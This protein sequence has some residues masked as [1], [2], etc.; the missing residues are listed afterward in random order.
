MTSH[1]I[2]YGED[3][4]DFQTVTLT[5]YPKRKVA[6]HVHPDGSVQVDAPSETTDLEIEEAV[7]KK[8]RWVLKHITE[9]QQQRAQ[10]L[11]RQYISGESYFYLG[12]RHILKITEEPIEKAS[13]K[14][15]RGRLEVRCETGN[16]GIIKDLLRGWYRKRAK[17]VFQRHLHAQVEQIPWLKSPPPWKLV[18]MQKQWGSCSPKGKLSLNPH[19]VKAP[20]ECVDYVLL[21]ELCHLKEHNHSDRFYRLLDELMPGWKAVKGKLDGMA[22]LLLNE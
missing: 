2:F 18:V 7:R 12:R 1:S 16:P 17:E 20:R 8:A 9:A 6:I 19:L 21:H 14:M 22:E 10:V 15:L 4:I 13:I 3:R 11:P 5:D